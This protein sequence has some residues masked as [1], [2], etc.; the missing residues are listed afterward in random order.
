MKYTIEQ[1]EAQFEELIEKA[2]AGEEVLILR[3]DR[4]IA[5][6]LAFDRPEPPATG[7]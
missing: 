5:R 1:A 7:E 4:P 6:L 3:E 2:E